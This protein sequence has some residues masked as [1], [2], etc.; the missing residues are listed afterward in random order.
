ME[1]KQIHCLGDSI[2]EAKG[3]P[4]IGRWP[5]LLQI[6]LEAQAPGVY[7][8]YSHGVGGNTTAMGLERM[9][10]PD[11]GAGITLIEFGLNDCSCAGYSV[12]NRVSPAEYTAN[13]Q[14]MVAIV[15]KRQG[16]PL[17][18]TNHLPI[19]A[20]EVLQGDQRLYSEKVAEYNQLV[21]ELAA[22]TGGGLID[23]EAYFRQPQ[24]EGLSLR[25]DGVHLNT[26]GNQVYADGVLEGLHAAFP[27]FG[28]P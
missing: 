20:N 28:R 5:V 1:R 23:M 7:A 12:K 9:R 19:Y 25:K 3:Q 24:Y 22:E 8:V 27:N 6:R 4:E 16:V 10:D 21:R 14:A 18:L 26:A 17:L 11:I 2:T 13:L 15:R